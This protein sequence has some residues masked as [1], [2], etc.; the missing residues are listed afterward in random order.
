MGTGRNGDSGP[1]VP[2]RVTRDL[3]SVT[4]SVDSRSMEVGRVVEITSSGLT[5][6]LSHVIVRCHSHSY[7][8]RCHSRS[9][10]GR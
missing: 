4:A 6:S 2:R 8:G 9:Y 1:S 7:H 10:R 5:V 3:V